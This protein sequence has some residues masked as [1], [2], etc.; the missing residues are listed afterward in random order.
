M[1]IILM[2]ITVIIKMVY[3]NENEDNNNENGVY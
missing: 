1:K 2:K 3:I